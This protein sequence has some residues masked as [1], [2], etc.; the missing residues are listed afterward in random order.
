MTGLEI[1]SDL[2]V[3]SKYAKYLEHY[4]RRENW[5]EVTYRYLKMM[6]KKFPDLTEDILKYGKFILDKKVLPSMRMLQFAGKAVE[7]NEIRGYNCS[8]LPI[9]D[10]RAFSEVMFLLLSGTGVG[11]SVQ[12]HHIKQLPIINKSAKNRRFVISDDIT[13]WA[14]SIKALMKY[15]FGKASKPVFDYS[16]IR[17]KGTPLIT[18]GGKAPGAEPLKTCHHHIFTILD[19]KENGEQLSS[20]EVHDILCHIANCVLAG[21]IRRAAM[22]SLFDIDDEEMLTCKFGNWWETDEQRGRS[23]NSAVLERDVLTEEVFFNLWNKIEQSGSGE[24]GFY[25]TNNKNWGV[26]PCCE[27]ALR[28]FQCC[29]LC[30]INFSTIID[31]Q[32]FEDR[33]KAATFFGTLQASF[34]DF[35]YLREI[36]S[37]TCKKDALLGIGMTGLACDKV[38]ELDFEKAVKEVLIPFNKEVAKKIGINPAARNS[39]VKPSGTTSCV[40]STA[41]GIHEWWSKYY[42]RTIRFNK[43][44]AIVDYLLKTNPYIVEDDVLRPHDTVCIRIPIKAPDGAI[45]RENVT[46]IDLLERIKY[47]SQKWITPGH[48]NGDNNHNVSATISINNGNWEKV[49]KWMW[50][51]KEFYNGLSVLPFWG[52]TY[53]QAPFEEITE[54]VYNEYMKNL[55]NIDLTEVLEFENNVQLQNEAACAGGACEV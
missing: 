51:N 55:N 35:Y 29:N 20:L 32:D 43:N 49:G 8:Y 18:S 24:P 6:S 50:D 21:G 27:I 37:E 46:E 53:K 2:T 17:K 12:N 28:P 7:V 15:A 25:L 1:L 47:I 30:E 36:W 5:N 23:N 41:S 10:Y 16:N 26:N 4:N 33:V 34:T 38:N 44:E 52:G 39:C 22:I 19:R 45:L 3:W 13:G 42:L 31:Q 14:D 54:D 48:I 40:L 11:Y 9:D